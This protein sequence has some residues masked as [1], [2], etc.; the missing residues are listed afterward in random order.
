M[1]LLE[2]QNSQLA[3]ATSTFGDAALGDARRTA[4]LVEMA[5]GVSERPNGRVTQV[6]EG[7]ERE[8]AYRLLEN[9]AVAASEVQ[10]AAFRAGARSAAAFNIVFVPVD[11]SALGLTD[12][13]GTHFGP[14][15]TRNTGVSGLQAVSALLVSPEGVPVGLGAQAIWTRSW[16]QRAQPHN[17]RPPVEETELQRWIDVLTTS[18]E[19][20][21]ALAPATLPWFQLDRGGDATPVLRHLARLDVAYTVRASSNRRVAT[22]TGTRSLHEV[23]G[24]S[25]WLGAYTLRVPATRD[26]AARTALVDVRAC[27]V[28]LIVPLGRSGMGPF[29]QFAVTALEARERHQPDGAEPIHWRLLTN[30]SVV[31]MAAAHDVIVG[32]TMRWRV[33]EFHLAWKSG[34]CGIEDS[35]LRSVAAFTKWATVLATV[36]IRAEHLKQ[37]SRTTPELPAAAEFSRDEID[38]V[39]LLRK[40]K[41]VTVGADATV[42]QLVYWIADIGGYTG[43]SSGGPPGVR[44]ITR[45][46][47]RV[48]A[49]A[50]AVTALRLGN[51]DL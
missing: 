21:A 8:A 10:Q 15:S 49:A 7:A 23:L 45:G 51:G 11:Q 40:P 50:A 19:T 3:W 5:A 48:A 24:A 32:Y 36:A 38:A 18:A 14:L 2:V 9:R 39:I 46:L 28:K 16:S 26:R 34:A 13:A 41:G 27:V 4:R 33:E 44:I 25:R 37:L 42:G 1:D 35:L 30:R 43:K 31:T 22:D 47:E 20:L 12:R 17:A 29:E 6:F